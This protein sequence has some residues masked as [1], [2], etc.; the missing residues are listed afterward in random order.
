MPYLPIDTE[1]KVTATPGGTTSQPVAQAQTGTGGGGSIGGGGGTGAAAPKMAGSF[2][3]LTDYLQANASNASDPNAV[4]ARSS[5]FDPLTSQASQGVQR[6]D[7]DSAVKTAQSGSE[8]VQATLQKAYG[9]TY[10]G[11][12]GQG[13]A[14]LDA[15]I[16]GRTIS[17]LA[18]EAAKTP[19][20]APNA[21]EQQVIAAQHTQY[22]PKGPLPNEAASPFAQTGGFTGSTVGATGFASPQEKPSTPGTDLDKLQ[23][24]HPNNDVDDTYAYHPPGG[25]S[26]T[27]S[28]LFAHGGE[29]APAAP[30]PHPFSKL[31]EKMRYKR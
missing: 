23:K 14:A 12:G 10:G 2:T 6:G 31:M 20:R 3:N 24:L 28:G 11:A 18:G 7:L 5:V 25:P 22:D 26:S 27:F 1:E 4:A 13:K 17:N 21:S 16:S 19:V 9:N 8:G 30:V 29:I 15:A